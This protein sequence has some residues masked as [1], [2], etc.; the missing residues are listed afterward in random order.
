[1]EIVRLP[2]EEESVVST[3]QFLLDNF[4]PEAAVSGLPFGQL[5]ARKAFD[6]I[7]FCLRTGGIVAAH[8]EYGQ[9]IGSVGLFTD[10]VWF[11]D[12]EYL[13]DGWFYV[14]P[15]FRGTPAIFQMMREAEVVAKEQEKPLM[16][17]VMNSADLDRKTRLLQ[18]M[19]YAHAG[20]VFV[21]ET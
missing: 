15:A 1:M 7:W 3:G 11:C 9:M 21:K 6:F 8:N 19:G 4:L 5:N 17:H 16:L 13:Q 20:G 18:K 12:T 14:H 10:S 2:Q